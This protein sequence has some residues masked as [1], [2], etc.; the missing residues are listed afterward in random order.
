MPP[1]NDLA[2]LQDIRQAAGRV[3]EA[4]GAVQT[5]SLDGEDWL[6]VAAVERQLTVIGE[7]VKRLSSEFRGAHPEVDWRRWAGL[8]DV[9]MHAYDAVDVPQL[10]EIARTDVAELLEFLNQLGL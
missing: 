3:A 7:A 1:H 8:R 9:V 4:L 5:G 6:V 2:S 10:W